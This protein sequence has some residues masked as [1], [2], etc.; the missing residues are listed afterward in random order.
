MSQH[1]ETL[2]ELV[3]RLRQAP[4]DAE[5][6]YKLALLLD[7]SDQ[8]IYCLKRV[9]ALEPHHEG[10]AEKL[11]VLRGKAGAVA[12]PEPRIP[13]LHDRRIFGTDVAAVDRQQT[14][15]SPSASPPMQPATSHRV[16]QPRNTQK[17]AKSLSRGDKVFWGALVTILGLIICS[18]WVVVFNAYARGSAPQTVA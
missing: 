17:R 8:V 13:T 18:I 11:A 16:N 15:V 3:E 4:N 12:P 10:A 1:E 2:A 9:L 5:S 6:W 14:F 7:E